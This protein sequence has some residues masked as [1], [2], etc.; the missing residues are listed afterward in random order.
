MIK[1]K[2]KYF[3]TCILLVLSLLIEGCSLSFS[4]ENGENSTRVD[5]DYEINTSIGLETTEALK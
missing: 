3:L 5:F 2:W 1:I 4:A